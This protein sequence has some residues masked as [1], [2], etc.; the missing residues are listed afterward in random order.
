[1]YTSNFADVKANA[2]TLDEKR[3]HA[4]Y[5]NSKQIYGGMMI[6][7]QMVITGVCM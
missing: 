4:Q 5:L 7:M 6:F 3:K 1:M 2:T